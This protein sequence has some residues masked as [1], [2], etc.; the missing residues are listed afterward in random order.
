MS[1]KFGM[2]WDQYDTRRVE[3]LIAIVGAIRE[4]EEIENKKTLN[5]QNGRR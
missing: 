5:K 2:D 3:Y 1:E 4:R